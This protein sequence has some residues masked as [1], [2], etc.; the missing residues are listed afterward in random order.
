MRSG[1]TRKR[2]RKHGT[3]FSQPKKRHQRSTVAAL[4]DTAL[5]TIDA[6]N[7]LST[8]AFDNLSLVDISAFQQFEPCNG[9]LHNGETTKKV[10]VENGLVNVFPKNS[11]RRDEKDYDPKLSELK[12]TSTSNTDKLGII[13][14]QDAN[15]S[16]GN[17]PT[18]GISKIHCTETVQNNRSTGAKRRKSGSVKRFKQEPQLSET[19]VMQNITIGTSIVSGGRIELPGMGNFNIAGENPSHKN[20]T[21]QSENAPRITKIIKPIGYSASVTNNVQDVSVTFMAMRYTI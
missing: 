4:N 6:D 8:A 13:Q 21:D 17:G 10:N 12:T 3:P 1:K 16:Q 5:E 14:F 7:P 18:D 2:K 11:G 20:K 15:T 9:N 19:P